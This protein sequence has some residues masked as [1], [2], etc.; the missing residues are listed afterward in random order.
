MR[1]KGPNG[2]GGVFTSSSSSKK[3]SGASFSLPQ[4]A[5]SRA[6]EA[7]KAPAPMNNMDALLALQAVDDFK[8]RRKRALKKGHS[9]LDQLDDLKLALLGGALDVDKLQSLA[10]NLA[11]REDLDDS[12][13]LK[14]I[15]D[16]IE[17]RAQVELAKLGHSH[18]V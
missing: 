7:T 3:A 16:E 1:V 12:P 11:V 17:L 5:Q 6:A 13:E 15:L 14:A 18:L 4:T 10:R 9:L 2:T 8:E